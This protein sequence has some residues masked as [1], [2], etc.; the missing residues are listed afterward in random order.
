MWILQATDS[1]SNINFTKILNFNYDFVV[2]NV[3]VRYY[4]SRR[5]VELRNT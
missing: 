3:H 4:N 5:F 2:A 1:S